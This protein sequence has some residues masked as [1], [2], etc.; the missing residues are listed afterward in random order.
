MHPKFEHVQFLRKSR[1]CSAVRRT[2]RGKGVNTGWTV[3]HKLVRISIALVWLYQG[4]WCKVLARAPHHLAVISAVPFVGPVGGRVALVLLG[5]A[6]CLLG[7]WV[8]TGWEM[9]WAAIVQTVLLAA[10][11]AGGVIWARQLIPDPAGMIL[12]NFAFVLLIWTAAEGRRHVAT[13]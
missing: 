12:Q 8:L 13:A 4:L 5:V 7:A 6:E 10:M 9:R 2:G 3:D 1:D 11:N